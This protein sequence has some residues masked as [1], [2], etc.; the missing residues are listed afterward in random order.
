MNRFLLCIAVVCCVLST[1]VNASAD[2]LVVGLMNVDRPPY[3]WKD[4]A[5]E[6]HGIF[7]EVLHEL[8]KDTEI[9]FTFK[10]LP[11]A[12]LRLYMVAGKLDVEMGIAPQWRREKGEVENSV[13]SVPFMLSEEVY[14]TSAAKGSFDAQKNVPSGDKF[15]GVIGFSKPAVS[16]NINRQDFLCEAQLLKMIDKKRCDYTIMPLD[17]YRYLAQGQLYHI[18]A[19]QP[20]STHNMRLRLHKRNLEL[21]PRLDAALVRMKED[22]RLAALLDR[23]S[24][25]HAGT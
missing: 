17:I 25:E 10:A 14:V 3:F 23:Y 6:Y 16:G 20:I 19:S 1:C 5:G 13:Y 21:L 2:S 18:A 9:H 8:E 11:K 4:S 12:R 24:K 22:G 15:C 7:I